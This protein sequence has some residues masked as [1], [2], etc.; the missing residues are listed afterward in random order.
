MV[1]KM[2]SNRYHYIVMKDPKALTIRGIDDELL[3]SMR[4]AASARGI[5]MN[6]LVLDILSEALLASGTRTR[7]DDLA[8]LAGS[9]TD[10][11][12]AE[13]DSAVAGFGKIDEGMWR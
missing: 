13:F 9:W 4:R 7:I 1:A 8:A 12:M 3:S 5:S 6:R 10:A 11:D 2:V